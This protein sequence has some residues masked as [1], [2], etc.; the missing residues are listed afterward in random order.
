[1]GERV[2]G[3]E[4]IT[5]APPQGSVVIARVIVPAALVAVEPR[6][7]V[8]VDRRNP[9]DLDEVDGTGED[10]PSRS[11]S[12]A[13]GKRHSIADVVVRQSVRRP[14]RLLVDV[15]Q[16]QR[17]PRITGMERKGSPL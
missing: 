9:L 1:M 15:A 3:V 16:N 2:L 13:S 6:V 5:P 17:P 7:V 4:V 10:K 11:G 12:R 8:V 14:A